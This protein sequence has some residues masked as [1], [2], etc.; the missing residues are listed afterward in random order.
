MAQS[1]STA[2]PERSLEIRQ[3]PRSRMDHARTTSLTNSTQRTP[4]HMQLDGPRPRSELAG[5]DGYDQK[6]N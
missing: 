5:H 1:S 3:T 6:W 2:D 4:G